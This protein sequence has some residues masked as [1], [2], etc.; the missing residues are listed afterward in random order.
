MI[1]L[2]D[3]IAIS[4]ADEDEI[5]TV[6]GPDIEFEGEISTDKSLMIKGRVKG[7]IH[8]MAEVYISEGAYVEADIDASQVTVRGKLKGDVNARKAIQVLENGKVEGKLI[9][10]EIVIEHESGFSGERIILEDKIDEV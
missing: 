8:S 4:V 3:K 2:V 6:L 9:A 1:H 10:P 7:V 5:D